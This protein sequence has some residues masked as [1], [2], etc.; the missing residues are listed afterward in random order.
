MQE[1]RNGTNLQSSLNVQWKLPLDKEDPSGEKKLLQANNHSRDLFLVFEQ[2]SSLLSRTVTLS[3]KSFAP[4]L[5]TD[6]SYADREG[7][8]ILD[9]VKS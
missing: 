1:F 4:F 2:T 8:I 6:R 3:E 9:A 5:T 7:A